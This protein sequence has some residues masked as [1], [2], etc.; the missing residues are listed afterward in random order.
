M[1]RTDVAVG[2]VT[3]TGDGGF[4]VGG[5]V[6]FEAGLGAFWLPTTSTPHGPGSTGAAFARS[7]PP[8][9]LVAMELAASAARQSTVRRRGPLFFISAMMIA[10]SAVRRCIALDNRRCG[11]SCGHHDGSRYVRGGNDDRSWHRPWGRATGRGGWRPVRCGD[12]SPNN[13]GS[14]RGWARDDHRRWPRSRPCHGCPMGWL[15]WLRRGRCGHHRTRTRPNGRFTRAGARDTLPRFRT[16]GG[17]GVDAG[18]TCVL[19]VA[20]TPS[21]TRFH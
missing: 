19:R 4:G 12:G 6:A 13:D 2:D 10:S 3:T 17:A 14:C 9:P 15:R 5:G 21:N 18:L 7:G 1:A 11:C 8:A 20:R 16:V